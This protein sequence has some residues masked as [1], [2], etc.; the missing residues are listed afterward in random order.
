M[1]EILKDS[2]L[3]FGEGGFNLFVTNKIF[4]WR[5]LCGK[6]LGILFFLW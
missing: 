2:I 1:S 6:I 4:T 5:Y 3:G